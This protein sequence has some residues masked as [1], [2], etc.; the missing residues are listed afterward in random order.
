M[1]TKWKLA[2][3]FALFNDILDLAGIGSVPIIGDMIDLASSAVLWKTLGARPTV[4]TL[5]E[6]VPGLDMLPIYTATVLWFY[7]QEENMDLERRKKR[8][9]E[10]E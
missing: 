4:P 7:Y 9:V 1:R 2:L 6:F 8:E 3:G 5:L 10:I